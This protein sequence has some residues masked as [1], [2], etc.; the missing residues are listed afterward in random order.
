MGSNNYV[1][2]LGGQTSLAAV[3]ESGGLTGS[4][5]ITGP[6][7]L[8]ASTMRFGKITDPLD[9]SRTVF[10]HAAKAS[11]PV[12]YG[13]LGRVEIGLDAVAGAMQKTGVTY[14]AA[15]EI[16]IPSARIAN[17]GDG[18]IIQ[19]HN[20]YP[21]STVTGPWLLGMNP[22]AIFPNRGLYFERIWS[23]QSNPGLSGYNIN[24][25][26]PFASDNASWAAS[27][28]TDNVSQNWPALA[29]GLA[30]GAWPRDQWVKVVVKYRGDPVGNTGILQVWM[31]ANGVTTQIVNETNVQL[32]TNDAPAGY[33]TDYIKSGLD[34]LTGGGANGV[35]E[36]R[37]SVYLYK[38]NGNTEP[39]IR[40]LMQ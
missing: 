11:D 21:P 33:P 28:T 18:T 37:R 14:W 2:L 13:H 12:T 16:Y 26:Y 25:T 6:S 4:G 24:Q 3:P 9:P 20:S 23:T 39:Q 31:T 17:G 19:V 10:Y 15:S 40:A 8:G 7:T 22:G 29:P 5:T 27:A 34:D 32:G 35:W 30:A 1:Q 38:D 36:L